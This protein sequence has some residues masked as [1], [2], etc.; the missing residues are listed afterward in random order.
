MK[1][2]SFLFLTIA[3]VI[4]SCK[5]NNY[6]EIADS[7]APENFDGYKIET[8]VD[9]MEFP[10][11]MVFLPDGSM[12]ITEQ[13]GELIHFKDGK[14]TLVQNIPTVYHKNQGGLLD[15]ELHPNYHE[16]GWIYFS[17]ST[18]IEKDG[19]GG[20]TAIMRAKLVDNK[21]VD[22]E[23]L[24][25]ATPNTKSGNHFGSRLEF[26]REGYLYFSI[27]DRFNRD[28]NPQDITLD[29]GKIYRI[30]DDGTIPL[31]NPFYNTEGAKKAIYSYGHRN[32]QGMALHPVTGK[33]WIHEHGPQGGDEINIIHPGKNYGWPKI[34]YG[35]NY[36]DTK[37]TDDTS[38]PGMEQPLHYWTPSI[39]PSGMAFVTSDKYPNWKGNLMVG[40]LKF[41]YLNRCVI[42][43]NIV[44]KEEKLMED[45][46]GKVRNVRQAPDGYLYVSIE[47]LGIVRIVP[48]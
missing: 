32:P 38:L 25:K 27:G 33:I 13:K 10:W 19:K 11:G 36:N 28:V 45:M 31:D 29:N 5:K 14:K 8:I 4:T 1:K 17:M 21:L 15:I 47:Q 23:I 16:N 39:A 30:N 9:G 34:T 42:E 37:I 7:I 24:Y 35:I 20:N 40:S 6:A 26:D 41:K 18:N 43:D 46:V 22:Q 12:L 44:V 48:E 2:I 3:L